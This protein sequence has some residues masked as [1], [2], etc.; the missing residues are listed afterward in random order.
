[1]RI[2]ILGGTEFLGRHLIK[3][4]LSKGHDVTLF[5]RGKR[6]QSC[7][8]K[9][10]SRGVIGTATW[11]RSVV[12]AGM[13][14]YWPGFLTINVNRAIQHGLTFRPLQETI[15]DTFQWDQTRRKDIVLK[16][17]ISREKETE[18]LRKI[19]DVR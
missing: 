19:Q 12:A 5:N 3:N 6:I 8:P 16:A 15:R 13:L 14:D 10:R 11:K 9:S 18:L 17:G 2:L 4:A 7:F 1:M